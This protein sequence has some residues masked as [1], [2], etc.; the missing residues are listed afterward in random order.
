MEHRKLAEC[1]DWRQDG[2]SKDVFMGQKWLRRPAKIWL[3]TFLAE[4]KILKKDQ[5]VPALQH[6]PLYLVSVISYQYRL[7]LPPQ[8][9]S[10]H[11][12]YQRE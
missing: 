1:I 3:T 5:L 7:K 6:W 10:R 9:T 4:M 2:I 8:T 12:H 11:E